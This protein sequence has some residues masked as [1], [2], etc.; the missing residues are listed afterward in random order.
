MSGG[1]FVCKKD[2]C[3]STNLHSADSTLL[4]KVM[5]NRVSRELEFPSLLGAICPNLREFV[6]IFVSISSAGGNSRVCMFLGNTRRPLHATESSRNTEHA[7]EKVD[8]TPIEF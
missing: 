2:G 3:K 8:A 6:A 7:S 1:L 5:K 4:F